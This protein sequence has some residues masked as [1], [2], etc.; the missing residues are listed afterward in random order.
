M[1]SR[2]NDAK[3]WK[4]GNQNLQSG[5]VSLRTGNNNSRNAPEQ[6]EI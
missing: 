5:P 1:V 3:G 6:T 2:Y 4:R